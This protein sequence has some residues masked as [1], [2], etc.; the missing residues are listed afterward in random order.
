MT[1]DL[2]ILGCH[3]GETR[4]HRTSAFLVDGRL[5]V[6]AGSITGTLTLEEQRRIEVVLVSHAHMDHVRDLATLA[7]NRCQQGGPPMT[8][9]ATEGTIHVLKTHFFNGRL[10]PDFTQIETLYGPTVRF[11]VVEP[12][13]TI[14]LSGLRITAVMVNHTVETSAFV[15]DNATSAIAYSGDTGPTDRLWEVLAKQSNLRGLLVETSFPNAKAALARIS[16]HHTPASLNQDLNKLR[17]HSGMPVFIFHIKP[18]FQPQVEHEI[19][20]LN[21]PEVRILQLGDAF[22]L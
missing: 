19:K 5:A 6:D 17:A 21:R 9:A 1:I 18:L 22:M 4:D 13:T 3:G 20:Q 16:G 11:Q 8:I 15:I 7:D 10:W 2:R 12:E 14:E